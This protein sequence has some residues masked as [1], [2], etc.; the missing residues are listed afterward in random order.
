MGW[1]NEGDYHTTFLHVPF[2]VK[3][4]AFHPI[5]HDTFQCGSNFD[6][7]VELILRWNQAALKRRYEEGER[8][9]LRA[10][11]T[12]QSDYEEN[13]RVVDTFESEKG[14]D[15]TNVDSAA[16]QLRSQSG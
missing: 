7:F 3:F 12:V 15:T 10:P 5:F 14:Y 16:T 13:F 9:R 4:A 8:N 1:R 2:S 6:F 11:P